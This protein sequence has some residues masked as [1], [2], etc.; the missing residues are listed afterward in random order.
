MKPVNEKLLKSYFKKCWIN[1]QIYIARLNNN[2][3]IVSDAHFIITVPEESQIIES[4]IIFPKLPEVGQSYRMGKTHY[5]IDGPDFQKLIDDIARDREYKPLKVTNWNYDE[6]RL[7]IQKNSGIKKR[8]FI[9]NT[10]L[11]FLCYKSR[12]HEYV[13]LRDYFFYGKDPQKPVQVMDKNMNFV[14]V[15]FPLSVDADFKVFQREKVS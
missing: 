13:D 6:A 14:G 2:N 11:N 5:L 3:L 1:N 15:F 10:F 8:I 7:L 9:N 12:N 4:R